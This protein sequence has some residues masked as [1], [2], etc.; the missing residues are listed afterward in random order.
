MKVM[1]LETV[2]PFPRSPTPSPLLPGCSVNMAAPLAPGLSHLFNEVLTVHCPQPHDTPD[3][4]QLDIHFLF[5][6][7]LFTLGGRA[8]E[9]TICRSET[10]FVS[11]LEPL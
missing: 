11:K 5:S 4:S 9:K 6:K 7:A 8:V 10:G 3:L 2:G 1:R